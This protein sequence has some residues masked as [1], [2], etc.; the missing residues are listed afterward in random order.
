M[1]VYSP[2]TCEVSV[3]RRAAPEAMLTTPCRHCGNTRALRVECNCPR[4]CEPM[5]PFVLEHSVGTRC[6]SCS[7]RSVLLD[8]QVV[9]QVELAAMAL[10]MHGELMEVLRRYG[11]SL[12]EEWG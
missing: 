1:L 2:V 6:E 3:W 4:C 9:G 11:E 7:H 8:D 12:M 5:V 10:A